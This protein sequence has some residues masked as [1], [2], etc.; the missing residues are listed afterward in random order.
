[1][2]TLPRIALV[3]ISALLPGWLRAQPAGVPLGA[4]LRLDAPSIGGRTKAV[5]LDWRGD[6]LRIATAGGAPVVLPLSAVRSIEVSRGK[7]RLLGVG[8][9]AL[10]GA[11]IYGALGLAIIARWDPG[12]EHVVGECHPPNKLGAM[13]LMLEG[14]AMLGAIVGAIVGRERWQR[15][16]LPARTSLV[17]VRAGDRA[18]L[19]LRIPFA[20]R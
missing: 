20:P 3:A 2:R 8:V 15:L 7:S 18:G 4:R 9:G 19:A 1:M 11:G 17:P 13:V 6:S 10:W 14:G 12:C 5:L 16:P